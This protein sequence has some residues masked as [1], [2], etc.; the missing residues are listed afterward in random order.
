MRNAM[1]MFGLLSALALSACGGDKGEDLGQFLGTW[2]PISGAMTMTCQ[3]YAYTFSLG[4]VT[5]N[6]GVSSDLLQSAMGNTCAIMADVN[7]A[8][9]SGVS[10]QTCSSPDGSETMTIAGYTFVV[11]PDGRTGTENASGG[12][13][14]FDGGAAIPC[15][16]NE[17]GSYQKIGR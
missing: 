8:T 14:L 6:M 2:Q 4:N 10:G 15:T 17:T 12:I 5:W 9:A 7:G 16:F 3:G 11:A 13:T 1:K